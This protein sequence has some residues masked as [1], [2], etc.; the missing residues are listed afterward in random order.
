[1]ARAVLDPA[2]IDVFSPEIT[3]D[4]YPTY[5]KA[6]EAGPVLWHPTM[7]Q[8]LVTRHAE[9]QQVFNDHR[10]FS[11]VTGLDPSGV[12]GGSKTMLFSD[13]PDHQR[14]R[15]P[16]NRVFTPKNVAKLEPRIRELCRQMVAGV[17]SREPYDVV[18]DL[19]YPLPVTVIAEMMGV[20]AEDRP[21]F[22]QWSDDVMTFNHMH[23]GND[24]RRAHHSVT[25][26]RAYFQQVI[27]DR[28]RSPQDDLVGLLVRANQ[29]DDA[30]DDGELV[31]ACAVILIGGNETTT[32]LIANVILALATFPD[33]RMRVVADPS[34]V[35]A[36]IEESLRYDGPAHGAIRIA[37][38]DVELGGEE[39][40][41]GSVL[42]PL[43]G[44]AG[45][46]P[47][48]YPDPDTFDIWRPNAGT[49][50]QFGHGIH[51]CIGGPLA[52]L[53]ARTALE[54]FLR[55]APDFEPAAGEQPRYDGFFFRNIRHLRVVP[56]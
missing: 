38:Q 10:L 52:R 27:E 26:L 18:R 14:L 24:L 28:R 25:E 12:F 56:R 35:P 20:S 4:P 23:E 30:L 1:M 7:S 40:P 15:N 41:A 8:W 36:A 48:E 29:E 19:A 43:L 6:R 22:K 2:V 51:Y 37:A 39:I 16:V 21:L 3:P 55:V 32:T 45:R 31:A 34:L 46:D 42:I 53:E 11:S 9:A 33:Q 17:G 49:H 50:L 44:G 47:A 54:E 5:T 13:P